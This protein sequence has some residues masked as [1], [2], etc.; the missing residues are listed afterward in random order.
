[1]R[2]GSVNNALVV[3][4][5]SIQDTQGLSNLNFQLLKQR[6]AVDEPT[7]LF[8]EASR[9]VMTMASVVSRFRAVSNRKVVDPAPTASVS[10]EQSEEPTD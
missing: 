4:G 8:R 9:K 6:G 10:V 5:A 7:D 3:T 1:M 2:W